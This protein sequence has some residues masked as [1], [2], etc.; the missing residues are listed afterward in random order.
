MFQLSK[1]LGAQVAVRS[2]EPYRLHCY[3]ILASLDTSHKSSMPDVHGKSHGL[4]SAMVT[5]F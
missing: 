5:G 3:S 2:E 1:F 4:T